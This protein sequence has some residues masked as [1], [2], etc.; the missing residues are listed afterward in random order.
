MIKICIYNNKHYIN[1]ITTWQK[2]KVKK[3]KK[4]H[5]VDLV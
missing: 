2:V 4:I 5:L 1:S 3:K